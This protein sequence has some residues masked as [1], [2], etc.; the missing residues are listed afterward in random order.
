[1]SSTS[2]STFEPSATVQARADPLRVG[3]RIFVRHDDEDLWAQVTAIKPTDDPDALR[4]ELELEA[5][6]VPVG[7]C[8]HTAPLDR[9]Y[10]RMVR[11]R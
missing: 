2:N 4:L 8:R 5:D 7:T 9:L 11:S 6:G 1:M 3:D 10:L